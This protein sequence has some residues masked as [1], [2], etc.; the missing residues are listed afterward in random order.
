MGLKRQSNI[1][2]CRMASILLVMILHSTLNAI[3]KEAGEP[4][5]I[6]YYISALS[7]IGVNVFVM[8][9]GYFSAVPKKTSLINLAFICFFWMLFKLASKMYLGGEITSQNF[10][11]LTDS[12]WFIP[13]YIGFL[14]MAPMLNA[15]A[16]VASKRQLWGGV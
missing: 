14:F 12:N 9:T 5:F 3:A 16:E 6:I 10:F 11:F 1:E 15:F 4:S 7:I 2:L 8:I 13:C